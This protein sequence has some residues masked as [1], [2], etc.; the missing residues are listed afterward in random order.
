M[1]MRHHQTEKT[2]QTWTH[3]YR[4]LNFH[5][6]IERKLKFFMLKS[7]KPRKNFWSV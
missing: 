5:K 4:D 3:K 7:K 2:S 6:I 1:I